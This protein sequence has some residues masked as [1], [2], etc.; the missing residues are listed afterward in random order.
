MSKPL[1]GPTKKLRV[2][3]YS[4]TGC[5]GDQLAILNDTTVLLGLAQRAEICSFIMA[6]SQESDQE[7]RLDLAIVEG[8]ICSEQERTALEKLRQRSDALMALGTCAVWGG[9]PA[10]NAKTIPIH[11]MKEQVYGD[12]TVFPGAREAEPLS[13]F[14]KVDY[15][16]T[17][18]PIEIDEFAQVVTAILNGVRPVQT[19]ASVCSE[20]RIAENR[21]LV[22]AERRVCCG[23]ITLAGCKARC[24]QYGQPCYG[25]RGPVE[26]PAYVATARL[27]SDHGLNKGAVIEQIRRFT[28]PA[29]VENRLIP[30]Y[31]DPQHMGL[32]QQPEGDAP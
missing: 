10:M 9:L 6:S 13:R 21:C 30:H 22:Q 8:S 3:I 23:P 27:F 25:C 29:W 5:A 26:D 1:P 12:S 4:F 11:T 19:D 7:G 28:A 17:G 2:G 24:I 15:A 32:G 14:V 31:Q 16:V 18:C 20:C